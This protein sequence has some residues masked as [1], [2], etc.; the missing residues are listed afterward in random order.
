MKYLSYLEEAYII[1][2]VKRYSVKTKKEL[3]YYAK[4][5]NALI[6]M[7]YKIWVYDNAGKEIDFLAQRGNK[8]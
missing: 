7:G 3:N 1:E 2:S 5:Y 8:K 6:Y 4:I